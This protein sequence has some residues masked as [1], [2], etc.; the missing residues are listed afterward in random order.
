M[1][2][3]VIS[4]LRR[5]DRKRNFQ[6]NNLTDYKWLEGIDGRDHIFR[7]CSAKDGWVNPFNGRPLLQN[8]VACLLSHAKAWEEVA[9]Q[10]EP[11]I[12]MEDD[13]VINDLW[14]EDVYYQIVRHKDCDFLYLQRNENEPLKVKGCPEK[15]VK[16]I[17]RFFDIP[18]LEVPS[19][20]YNLTAYCISPKGAKI[21]LEALDLQNVIPADDFVPSCFDILNVL[22]LKEDACNQLGRESWSGT[23]IEESPIFKN[24]KIH[25]LTTGDDRKKCNQ[26]HT[27]AR[28]YGIDI[29]N[30]GLNVEWKGTDMTAHGGG[31]KVNLLH[32]YIK[33]LPDEDIVLFTDA[34]DVFYADDINTIYERYVDLSAELI[35]G[36][37]M[38]CW[39]VESIADQF[40]KSDT[41]YRYLNSGTIMGKVGALKK[42]FANNKCKDDEDDQLFYQKIF[43]QGEYDIGL[44]YEQY[45]FQTHDPCVEILNHQ[46]HNPITRCCP[47][48]YHGNGPDEAKVKFNELYYKLH[49]RKSALFLPN[50][51]KFEIISD[52]MLLIDFMT[53]DQCERLIDVADNNGAWGS[54][55]Y[56]KFPAQEIRMKELGLWDE[57]EQHWNNNVVPLY[58]HYWQPL[59]HY[60]LRDGFV[61]R[62]AMD[63]QVS[64][65]LHHDASLVTGSVKLNDDYEGAELVYPR[66]K[67]SNADIPVGK[68]ILFPGQVSHGH[69][70]LPLKSGVKY[71]LTIWTCRFVSD[72]I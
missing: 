7:E 43:L 68:C 4:L 57:L 55:E 19:F 5:T 31:H 42:L 66:Q 27:S 8:E 17:G 18:S 45:L 41:Q 48:I 72:T 13:A 26:L 71:S 15:I 30:I 58:E 54:L 64:L 32:N 16:D 38:F 2:K 69:E 47:C 65:N 25:T 23:D 3:L 61:M 21:L 11:M 50:L 24:F 10:N 37:E 56:D 33:D 70:C 60:G 51:G 14:N 22:A 39:P 9:N 12:I 44:D 63:T 52:D 1:K 36:A 46:L 29:V 40:P 49:P 6:R 53:Q 67:F 35:F 20:P 62:Y 34:F 59:Q 28:K